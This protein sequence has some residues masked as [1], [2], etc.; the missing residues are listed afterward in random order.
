MLQVAQHIIKVNHTVSN[1]QGRG[2]QLI[3]AWLKHFV[4]L[5]I[6]LVEVDS[7]AVILDEID[8]SS[9]R[10]PREIR[11]V[12]LVPPQVFRMKFSRILNCQNQINSGLSLH[13]F[14]TKMS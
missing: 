11:I 4:A 9:V 7:S 3:L 13:Y 5:S 12:R 10:R 14:L 2:G 8:G 1:L 6:E